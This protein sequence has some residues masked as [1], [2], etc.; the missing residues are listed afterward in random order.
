[1]SAPGDSISADAAGQQS[2][3]PALA[4]S[5]YVRLHTPAGRSSSVRSLTQSHS[6]AA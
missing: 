1:M 5:V 4:Y 2:P 6:G 3:S